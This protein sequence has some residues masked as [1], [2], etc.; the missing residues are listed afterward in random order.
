MEVQ[1]DNQSLEVSNLL[2]LLSINY[3]KPVS[4][5]TKEAYKVSCISHIV[6]KIICQREYLKIFQGIYLLLPSLSPIPY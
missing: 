4:Q 1:E 3:S 2:G 6:Y 5:T